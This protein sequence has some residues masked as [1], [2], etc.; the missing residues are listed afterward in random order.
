MVPEA[1]ATLA[2]DP[3]IA[4]YLQSIHPYGPQDQVVHTPGA[5]KLTGHEQTGLG[6]LQCN[7]SSLLQDLSKEFCAANRDGGE[8]IHTLS[9][10]S[11]SSTEFGCLCCAA[12]TTMK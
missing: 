11:I 4:E 9:F 10:H 6:P 5:S 3:D 2:D 7:S 1:I 12:A 8:D